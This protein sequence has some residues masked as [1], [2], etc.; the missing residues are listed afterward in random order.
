MNVGKFSKVVKFMTKF[1]HHRKVLKGKKNFKSIQKFH[2]DSEVPSAW[3]S[4]TSM[5]WFHMYGTI[6]KYE[7]LL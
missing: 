5:D 6:H 1:C 2:K 4:S 3:T 7:R